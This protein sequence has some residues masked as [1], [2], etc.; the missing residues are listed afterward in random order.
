MKPRLAKIGNL[1]PAD[2]RNPN[3]NAPG[4]F[5]KTSPN[6]N[7]KTKDADLRSC[8]SICRISQRKQAYSL[9]MTP[10]PSDRPQLRLRHSSMV[11]QHSFQHQTSSYLKH[12]TESDSAYTH[13][14]L[15]SKILRR[16]VAGCAENFA[17]TVDNII[18]QKSSKDFVD[19]QEIACNSDVTLFS[20][21]YR[22]YEFPTKLQTLYKFCK[23]VI[24]FPKLYNLAV[25][26]II[27][28]YI[29]LRRRKREKTMRR[30]LEEIDDSNMNML[31]LDYVLFCE[32]TCCPVSLTQF[33][34]T[35]LAIRNAN[36][37]GWI[38]LNSNE[39][40]AALL[41][42]L[43]RV[44]AEK[45]IPTDPW[46][47][48]TEQSTI[49]EGNI[50]KADNNSFA[51]SAFVGETR[52]SRYDKGGNKG[53]FNYRKS[54]LR[55]SQFIAKKPVKNVYVNFKK[56]DKDARKPS[57]GN[58][59]KPS[60]YI[61]RQSAKFSYRTKSENEALQAGVGRKNTNQ[62]VA[63]A[64]PP[65]AQSQREINI[66]SSKFALNTNKLTMGSHKTIHV[67]KLT[68]QGN[69]P[70]ANGENTPA[71]DATPAIGSP[72][73]GYTVPRKKHPSFK[74]HLQVVTH[75]A[76]LESNS[77]SVYA[78]STKQ[79]SSERSIKVRAPKQGAINKRSIDEYNVKTGHPATENPHKEEAERKALGDKDSCAQVT[80]V[81]S[82]MDTEKTLK[83]D[84]LK[85]KR[86]SPVK[87]ANF[88]KSLR[89]IKLHDFK[90]LSKP[91]TDSGFRLPF[92]TRC[93][94]KP[95]TFNPHDKS[96][97]INLSSTFQLI[98]KRPS[99]TQNKQSFATKPVKTLCELD[100]VG[101]VED[102]DDGSRNVSLEPGKLD[103]KGKTNR[104]MNALLFK[105]I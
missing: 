62:E 53:S 1:R 81:I 60:I 32:S 69:S 92:K 33:T 12:S 65:K 48:E 83:T 59:L 97:Q 98:C 77:G 82:P 94:L 89:E 18:E 47:F 21:Y 19:Y 25:F 24:V 103:S 40:S 52:D 50:Q 71:K 15:S 14:L 85:R 38:C 95:K 6:A 86:V 105:N 29:H 55:M 44:Q 4:S 73:T 96:S 75:R 72:K 16:T 30:I 80:P 13:H 9:K 102:K 45:E 27:R 26:S 43:L 91:Q 79:A 56:E 23:F 2:S 39:N 41:P 66:R 74:S 49:L 34:K 57:F 22:S 28:K 76:T 61:K 36:R 17:R 99:A 10:A 54:D 93:L 11:Q 104:L 78:A 87:E 90:P 31:S 5:E 63:L 7:A 88:G 51:D 67:R 37:L 84:V 70:K 68:K 46:P 20:R 100:E 101:E 3:A 58:G 64:G 8:C 42:D 35:K